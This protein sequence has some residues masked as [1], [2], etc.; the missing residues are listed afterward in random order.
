MHNQPIS[1]AIKAASR[2]STAHEGKGAAH[3]REK[4]ERL[5]R[6]FENIVLSHVIRGDLIEIKSRFLSTVN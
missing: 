4:W 1:K 2:G 5:V 3:F 6:K